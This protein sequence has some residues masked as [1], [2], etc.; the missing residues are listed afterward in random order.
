M[1]KQFPQFPL[2]GFGSYIVS[3]YFT[4]AYCSEAIF[5]HEQRGYMPFSCT[6]LANGVNLWRCKC[7]D[8]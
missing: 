2:Y 6:Y 3:P 7:N 5:S 1:S 8:V 4:Q